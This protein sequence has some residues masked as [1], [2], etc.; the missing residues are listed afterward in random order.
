MCGIAGFNWEDGKLMKSMLDETRH[1]GPDD[2]GSFF[3]GR[4]SLGHN[5]LSIIDVSKAGKQPMCDEKEEI[6]ITFNGEIYTA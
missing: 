1:R 4:V 6:W 2:S 3:G 5:R